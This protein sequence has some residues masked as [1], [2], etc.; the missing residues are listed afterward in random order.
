MRLRQGGVERDGVPIGTLCRRQGAAIAQYVAEVVQRLGGGGVEPDGLLQ[1]GLRRIELALFAQ[2]GAEPAMRLRQIGLQAD[3]FA[4]MPLRLGGGFFCGLFARGAKAEQNL[5]QVGVAK[6]VLR[7]HGH[8]LAEAQHGGGQ[9]PGGGQRNA[10]IYPA[11]GIGGAAFTDGEQQPHSVIIA[12]GL[13]RKYT[14]QTPRLD[15]SPGVR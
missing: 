2:S 5:C 13:V 3:G 7:L 4:K 15:R 12:P 14:E 9:A 1:G 10:E 6:R 8:G 11:R